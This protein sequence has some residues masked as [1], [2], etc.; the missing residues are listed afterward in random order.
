MSI[1]SK[2]GLYSNCPVPPNETTETIGHMHTISD[3]ASDYT[4]PAADGHQHKLSCTPCQRSRQAIGI[5]TWPTGRIK[6]HIH[7]FNSKTLTDLN[8]K[9][10]V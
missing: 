7:Y 1:Q 8:E 9:P 3:P 10:R 4:D 2:L 5:H 6:N